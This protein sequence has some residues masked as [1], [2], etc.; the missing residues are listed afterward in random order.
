M[1]KKWFNIA[2]LNFF[3]AALMGALMRYAFVSEVLWM[4]FRNI[5]Y[6]H[7]HTAML[8][9]IYLG[10]YA[11]LISTFLKN[12]T[13]LRSYS[14]FFWISELS[15]I[16]ML[17]SYAISGYGLISIVFTCLHII[18][19]Y[20]LVAL[21]LRDYRAEEHST[22]S[23]LF[24]KTSFFFQVLSTLALITIYYLIL[25][26]SSLTVLYYASVQFFLHFQFNGWFTFALLALLIKLLED[27]DLIIGH[28]GWL[29]FYYLLCISCLLT[30]A[31]AVAWSNP[32]PILF[33]INSIGVS[34]QLIAIVLFSFKLKNVFSKLR[35]DK[36]SRIFLIIAISS[37][38]IKVM[39]QFVV[40]IPYL[41][42]IAYTIRNFVIGFIHMILLA[43]VTVFLLAMAIEKG[44]IRTDLKLVSLGLIILLSGIVSSELYLFLQGTLL[45][46]SM[47]FLPFYDIT[48]FNLSVLMPIGLIF[49]IGGQFAFDHS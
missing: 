19:S 48:I 49:I 17:L 45:W 26:D 36:W 11:I 24:V 38:L 12:K 46:A 27:R 32:L 37:F 47:G 40:V 14:L 6:A 39:I 16:G 22:I 43:W 21:F 18:T 4:D 2:L 44:W 34:L 42:T 8:G 1:L 9:W 20:A 31:I 10:I 23:T 29:S 25:S 28:K 15:V 35:L 3:F 30:Y 7:Y 13:D 5:M 33:W 41:A